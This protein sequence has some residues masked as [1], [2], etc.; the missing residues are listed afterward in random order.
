MIK[1]K[2]RLSKNTTQSAQINLT[3]NTLHVKTHVKKEEQDTFSNIQNA[4]LI[5]VTAL[6]AVIVLSYTVFF[7]H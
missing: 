3:E 1:N 7:N 2:K 6:S 4:V 5:I